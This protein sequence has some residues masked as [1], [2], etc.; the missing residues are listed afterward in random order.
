MER[1][2][3]VDKLFNVVVVLKVIH[4]TIEIILGVTLFI[5]TKEFISS[6]LL[7][8][9]AEKLAGGPSSFLAQYLTRV[10]LHLSFAI[11]LFFSIYLLGHGLVN[12]SLIYGISRKPFIAYPLSLLIF[13]GFLIYQIYSYL[14]SYSLWMLL[15]TLFDS[16]F[17]I[18]LLYEYN[19]HLKKYSFLG[20]LKI[21]VEANNI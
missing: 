20:K 10:G 5:L 14:Q 17:I 11:K 7:F 12:L 1:I 8:I 3:S 13:F 2:K 21:I 16:L 18:L 4:A 9:V 6:T 15:I 19:H